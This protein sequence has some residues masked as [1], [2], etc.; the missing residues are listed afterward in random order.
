MT[1]SSCVTKSGA[2]LE[3]QFVSVA[4]V[5]APSIRATV[6]I[7]AHVNSESLRLLVGAT[8]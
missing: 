2:D 5:I 4:P 6:D 3:S 1:L 8:R 7:P